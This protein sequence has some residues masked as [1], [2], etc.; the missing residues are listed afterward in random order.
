MKKICVTLIICTLFSFVGHINAFAFDI[1]GNQDLFLADMAQG[2]IN[3]VSHSTDTSEMD[4]EDTIAIYAE[5]VGYEIEQMQKYT[6]V[7]FADEKFDVLAHQYINACQMQKTATEY[8]RNEKLYDALWSGGYTARTGIISYFYENYGLPITREVADLYVPDNAAV[9]ATVTISG[10][11]DALD[12]LYRLDDNDVVL[13]E[14]DLIIT[15]ATGQIKEYSFDSKR[16][17]SYCFVVKNNSPF[18]LKMIDVNCSVLDKDKNVLSTT[19]ASIYA[20]VDAGK[21]ANCESCFDLDNY[22]LAKYVRIDNISYDGD[23]DHVIHSIPVQELVRDQFIL[24]IE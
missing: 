17:Y 13:T 11:T 23:G 21:T 22:P 9:N 4:W 24:T 10:N 19:S 8:Y 12:R 2:I 20:T 7:H 3:R 18:S 15:R 6:S 16:Y 1:Y 5:L 14:N